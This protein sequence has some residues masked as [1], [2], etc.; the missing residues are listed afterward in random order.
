[1]AMTT[2]RERYPQLIT[3]ST[4]QLGGLRFADGSGSTPT[5]LLR[6]RVTMTDRF[7]FV[8]LMSVPIGTDPAVSGAQWFRILDSLEITG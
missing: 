3:G 2:A 7:A 1:M 8:V 5:D 6:A 4:Q